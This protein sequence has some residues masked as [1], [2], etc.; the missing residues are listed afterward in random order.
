VVCEVLYG[1]IDFAEQHVLQERDGKK[2]KLIVESLC[3]SIVCVIV[4]ELKAR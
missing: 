3:A 1:P 4:P 2:I